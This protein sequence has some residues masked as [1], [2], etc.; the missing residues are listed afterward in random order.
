MLRAFEGDD[1]AALY[2]WSEGLRAEGIV[3]EFAKLVAFMRAHAFFIITSSAKS[4]K[5]STFSTSSF[6]AVS[7]RNLERE[8]SFFRIFKVYRRHCTVIFGLVWS[9]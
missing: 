3:S 8:V 2:R 5:A 4:P 1:E 7:K 9:N 6:S